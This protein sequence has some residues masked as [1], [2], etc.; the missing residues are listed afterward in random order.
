MRGTGGGWLAM[1]APLFARV[2]QIKKFRHNENFK[3]KSGSG[4]SESSEVSI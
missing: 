2:W 3:L 4:E 1:A